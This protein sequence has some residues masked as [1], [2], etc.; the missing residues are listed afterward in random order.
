MVKVMNTK[1]LNE[2]KTQWNQASV[3]ESS[4]TTIKVQVVREFLRD[5]FKNAE[6]ATILN[7]GKSYISKVVTVAKWLE[8]GKIS[9][10]DFKMFMDKNGCHTLAVLY[11]GVKNTEH[12]NLVEL[13]ETL[14]KDTTKDKARGSNKSK[15][16]EKTENKTD[17]NKTENKEE[18]EN[19]IELDKNDMVHI[20]LNGIDYRIPLDN[21]K[22]YQI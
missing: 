19:S 7:V 2:L 8:N 22:E 5:G 6:I 3:L 21:L 14:K 12:E 13:S 4:A 18:F 10:R 16:S 15:K 11:Q 20:V 1:K 17:E 9:N